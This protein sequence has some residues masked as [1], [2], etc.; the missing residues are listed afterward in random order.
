MWCCSQ[1]PIDG[2]TALLLQ[3]GNAAKIYPARNRFQVSVTKDL[4]TSA[5]SFFSSWGFDCPLAESAPH[6]DLELVN[7]MK[8]FANFDPVVSAAA[9]KAFSRH[10]WYLLGESIPLALWDEDVTYKEKNLLADS[11][12]SSQCST[13]SAGMELTRR[14]GNGFDKPELPDVIAGQHLSLSRCAT[15][16]STMFFRILSIPSAFLAKPATLWEDDEDYVFG[17]E[18]IS[19]L[20]VCNDSAERGVKL[21]ANL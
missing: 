17:S 13:S 5:H 14:Y 20:K 2:E 9:L 16:D 7:N 12:N 4:L 1:S 19:G 15:A 11:I 8:S 6:Q 10:T 21:V 3:N 18:I